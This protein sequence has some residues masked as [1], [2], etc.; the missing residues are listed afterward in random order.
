MPITKN[1][2]AWHGKKLVWVC[3][4]DGNMAT[5]RDPNINEA[6]I[7]DLKDSERQVPVSELEPM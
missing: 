3:V 4:L 6:R 2:F 5:V 1:S 7:A